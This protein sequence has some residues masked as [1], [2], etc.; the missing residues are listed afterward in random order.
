MAEIGP[1]AL[2]IGFPAE[3]FQDSEE[4][5]IHLFVFNPLV[6]EQTHQA[7]N[8]HVYQSD[9]GAPKQHRQ[10]PGVPGDACEHLPPAEVPTAVETAV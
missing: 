8:R 10:Q 3:D 2:A 6:A 7:E 1:Q 5:E 4:R 9:E